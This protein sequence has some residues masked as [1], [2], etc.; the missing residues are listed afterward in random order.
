MMAAAI[1]KSP[2]LTNMS[3]RL[4]VTDND[5]VVFVAYDDDDDKA[6][7]D[8]W[9]ARCLSKPGA[10]PSMVLPRTTRARS[11]HVAEVF[12]VAEIVDEEM[13]CG[14]F[15]RTVSWVQYSLKVL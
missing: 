5:V 10:K 15:D 14:S 4:F 3:R 12:M 1:P 11:L 8:D 9:V 7:D 2:A 6:A 13:P